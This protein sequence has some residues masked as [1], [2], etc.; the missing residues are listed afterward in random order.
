MKGVVLYGPPASGKSTVTAA[1][2]VLDPRFV[3]LRKLKAGD[4]R[5]SE[6]EFISAERMAELRN[7]GR[8]LVETQRYGNTYAVDRYQVERMTT[9]GQI[10]IV[11][12]GNIPDIHR[13]N[14]A[15][16]WL[17]ALLWVSREV[18]ERRSRQRLDDDTSQRLR[19]WD[20]TLADRRAHDD[21][22]FYCRYETDEIAPEAI[23]RQI[24]CAF[25]DRQDD[26]LHSPRLTTQ[27]S[28]P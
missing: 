10:P 7:A 1:L 4:R 23:A 27:D 21:S 26:S 19:A 5:G 13:L 9:A 16:P 3:L 17:V 6:Y 18:C 14:D 20:E 28:V 11:H 15:G 24:A 25:S 2:T 22:L 12:M 8:L